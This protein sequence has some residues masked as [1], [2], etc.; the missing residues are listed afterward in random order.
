M[1]RLI[2]NLPEYHFEAY[3]HEEDI[4]EF[5]KKLQR[6]AP[7]FIRIGELGKSAKGR[8]ITLFTITDFSSGEAE[9]KPAFYI[10]GMV[11]SHEL[12]S[13]TA[14]L[15]AARELIVG[16]HSDGLLEKNTFYIVPRINPDGAELVLSRGGWIRSRLDEHCDR[17]RPNTWV[18]ED[19]DGNHLILEMRIPDPYGM[20]ETSPEDS[21]A[22]QLRTPRSTGPFYSILPEGRYLQ[23]DGSPVWRDGNERVDWNRNYGSH[24]SP[25]LKN[26]GAFPHSEQELYCL[27][28]F[29]DSHRNIVGAA[30]FHNGPLQILTAPC[31]PEA[32]IAPGDREIFRKC[33]EIAS[34][35]GFEMSP[36]CNYPSGSNSSP[37]NF[38]DWTYFNYG[39]PGFCIELG[40]IVSSVFSLDEHKKID[41]SRVA[42][43]R[44]YH[45][46]EEHPE[47]PTRLY[48]WKKFHHPQLGEVEIGGI[49]VM[50]YS[51]PDK[52]KMSSYGRMAFEFCCRYMEMAPHLIGRVGAV[53]SLAKD[54]WRVRCLVFNEGGLSTALTARG[55]SLSRRPL[56]YIE[57][58]PAGEIQCL[59]MN[60]GMETD[61]FAAWEQRWFE[62]FLGG[63]AVDEILG[64]VEI[65]GC[66]GI[67]CR[68][69]VTNIAGAVAPANLEG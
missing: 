19:I 40:T 24:W 10:Q 66:C 43:P 1:K 29:F 50:A 16:H 49:D 36:I 17:T 22:M 13:I 6:A 3:F 31:I 65:K 30:D 60:R 28:K 69:K 48:E 42:H 23:Y 32:S 4:V 68:I 7:D 12:G 54:I 21:R 58:H 56:P 38:A 63:H 35:C 64:E 20:W 37:G 33:K 15:F 9:N 5:G 25:E 57:F 59:S 46:Q 61:H 67:S 55:A 18:E 14:P 53:E 41:C 52:E 51:M 11:H 62:W 44:I 26:S 2:S 39:I 34:R 47:E 8:P 45:W 27:G